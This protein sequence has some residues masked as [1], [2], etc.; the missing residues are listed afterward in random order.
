M[1]PILYDLLE[2]SGPFGLYKDR[3]AGVEGFKAGRLYLN[4]AGYYTDPT[5]KKRKM[6]PYVFPHF[7][8]DSTNDSL[9]RARSVGNLLANP[10]P[11][12]YEAFPK[13]GSRMIKTYGDRN[14]HLAYSFD[15]PLGRR[16]FSGDLSGQNL[17]F[18]PDLAIGSQFKSFPLTEDDLICCRWVDVPGKKSVISLHRLEV[19][20]E[21]FILIEEPSHLYESYNFEKGFD[22]NTSPGVMYGIKLVRKCHRI[23]YRHNAFFRADEFDGDKGELFGL[24]VPRRPTGDVWGGFNPPGDSDNYSPMGFYTDRWGDRQLQLVMSDSGLVPP[25]SCPS[26]LL[27]GTE[28]DGANDW[29]EITPKLI[30]TALKRALE[31]EDFGDYNTLL[32][33]STLI[34]PEP[35]TWIDCMELF[36]GRVGNQKFI[37]LM[38]DV[39]V[40]YFVVTKAIWDDDQT[41][42]GDGDP[43]KI[44][45]WEYV[46]KHFAGVEATVKFFA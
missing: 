39:N 19:L 40:Y 21:G 8:N 37:D 13:A 41:G 43:Y 12:N 2:E 38:L 31:I 20:D 26:D 4:A 9:F 22:G 24:A 7:P 17:L 44:A 11:R 1:T 23:V 35:K 3:I 25:P 16:F 45:D 32:D 10:D 42:V 46:A 15:V 36:N 6:S 34:G 27:D 5:A 18:L 28:G 33:F 14:R 29:D 30:S